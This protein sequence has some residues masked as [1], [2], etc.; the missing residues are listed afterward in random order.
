MPNVINFSDVTTQGNTVLQQNLTVRGAFSTFS[1]NLF[2]SVTNFSTLGNS[3][4]R[5]LS[6]FSQNLN[7][8]YANTTAIL[9]PAGVI[10][11][12]TTPVAGGA[13]LQIQGN[14]SVSNSVVSTN[15]YTTTVNTFTTNTLAIFGPTGVIG[16]GTTPVV[17]GAALQV[18]GNLFAANALTAPTIFGSNINAS[19]LNTISIFGQ[20]GVIGINTVP[21]VGGAVLQIQGNMYASNAIS[22]QNVFAANV[23]STTTN[24]LVIYGPAGLVGV[25]TL[26]PTASLHVAGNAW[27]SNAISAPNVIALTM[28]T[29]TLNVVSILPAINAA[30]NVYGVGFGFTQNIFATVQ[31]LG[32]LY[33]SNALSAPGLVAT[34]LNTAVM[35][36]L[37]FYPAINASQNVFGVGV[38]LSQNI[39]ATFQVA[40]NLWASNAISAPTVLTPTLNATTANILTILGRSGVVGV[41]TAPI[42]GGALVQIQGNI[43]AANSIQTTNVIATQANLTYANVQ[44]VYGPQGVVGVNRVPVVGSATLQV[45][46]NIYATNAISATNL[47]ATN[48]FT[49]GIYGPNGII[50]IGQVP[51]IDGAILQI[52]GNVYASNALTALNATAT[53]ANAT[54]LNVLSFF[55][56]QSVIGVNQVPIVGGAGI[57]ISGNLYAA[58]AVSAPIITGTTMNVSTLNIFSIFGKAGVTGVNQVPVASG[59]TLQVDGNVWASNAISAPNVVATTLNTT[60]LNVASIYPAINVTQNILGVGI[61]FTQNVMAALQVSGNVYA[62]NAIS[63]QNVFVTTLNAITMNLFSLFPASNAVSNNFGIG[64]GYTQNIAA[65]LQVSGNIYASNS[66]TAPTI[67]TANLNAATVNTTAIFSPAGLLGIGTSINLGAT[68]QVLGNIYV[69]TGMIATNVIAQSINS[70]IINTFSIVGAAGGVGVGTTLPAASLHVVGNVYASNGLQANVLVASSVNLTSLTVSQLYGPAGAGVGIGTTP[71]VGGAALQVL[72]N[73]YASNA[74]IAPSILL[75]TLNTVSINT[76]SLVGTYGSIGIGT[77]PVAGGANL[78]VVGNIYVSNSFLTTAIYAT[79]LNTNFMNVSTIFTGTGVVGVNQVPVF[80]SANL[81]ILGNLYASNAIQVTNV[82]ATNLNVTYINTASFFTNSGVLGIGT[83]PDI[84]GA[85]LQ[86]GGNLF[87]SNALFTNN[88]FANTVNVNI[89]NVSSFYS[90]SGTFGVGILAPPTGPNLYVVGNTF[91][92]NA[93]QTTNLVVSGTINYGED[94]FKRGPWLIP[95]TSNAAAITGWI[96]S[97]I[98]A[99]SVPQS[100]WSSSAMPAYGNVANGPLGSTEYS[101]SVVL[102]DGRVIFAPYSASNVG[103]FNPATNQFSTIIP[104]G[105]RPGN[106]R[107]GVLV[108]D[109]NVIFIPYLNSNVGVF[110][111]ESYFLTNV[112]A[113]TGFTG[114]VLLPSGNVLMVPD[115]AVNIGLF[116]PRELTYSA[117]TAA[118]GYQGGVLLPSGN[119]VFVPHTSITVGQYNPSSGAIQSTA[120]GQASPAFSGGVLV[121]NGRVVMVPYNSSTVAVYNPENGGSVATTTPTGAPA[122]AFSGGFLTP[123]GNVIFVP[124]SSSSFGVYDPSRSTYSTGGFIGSGTTKF[125]GGSLMLDGRG[126]FAPYSYANVVVLNTIGSVPPELCLSPYLNKF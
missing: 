54:T 106:Y 105:A 11:I 2:P 97:T 8:T 69:S 117:N 88:I 50:G 122:A 68:L 78:Q 110:N 47:F 124:Y 114:G 121:Q 116:D 83:T 74:I 33:A 100:W 16:I 98:N 35:N 52:A 95:S 30:Q 96:N 84:A 82:V 115:T 5:F 63:T 76:N 48:V 57:Q 45:S 15:L 56:T 3:T 34:T 70:S 32:N 65:A 12:G 126:I 80:G 37:A 4:A 21:V 61:G 18:Q 104:T 120:H 58:N 107:G 39:G 90:S 102:P 59:A 99:A 109:G 67:F 91:V 81:Q 125:V 86:V 42:T 119:V 29:T 28:N 1:G 92:S 43:F 123:S 53:T 46:G 112:T 41:G 118:T 36:V 71:V 24:T 85:N 20:S 66:I 89:V 103:V 113:T 75:Q 17:G 13:A 77:I 111:P 79:T 40:G 94:L 38:G 49:T 101:G 73:I 87:V 44:G 27:A 25:G 72:G 60:T 64:I 108:P 55:G 22:T 19:T 7:V 6:I 93:I 26:V 14:V 23:I 10:G 9:G 31:I 51:V 62:S